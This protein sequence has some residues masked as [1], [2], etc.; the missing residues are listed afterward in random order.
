MG[1]SWCPRPDEGSWQRNGYTID[2]LKDKLGT[3]ELATAEVTFDG[4]LAYPLGAP[5]RGIANL[6]PTSSSPRAWRASASRPPPCAGRSASWRRTRASGRPSDADRRLPRWYAGRWPEISA[7]RARSLASWFELLRL[8]RQRRYGGGGDPRLP[9]NAEPLQ[10]GPHPPGDRAPPRRHAAPRR[11]RRRGAL[12]AAAPALPGLGDH[13]DMGG[14]A[15]RALDQAL[16]DLARFGADPAE[17]VA[18]VAGEPRPTSRA[19]W[20]ASWAPRTTRR[21][22]SPSPRW[23]SGWSAP[24]GSAR[25]PGRPRA[26]PHTARRAASE[27]PAQRMSISADLVRRTGRDRGGTPAEPERGDRR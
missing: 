2:R 14:A 16:R 10:V 7:A 20:A 8:W 17:F 27:P 25:S 26:R 15:Q 23:R 19:S 21:P 6:V 3:R 1:S 22:S 9:R 4:A 24:P 5:D 18:R 12:L 11:Q 13:G